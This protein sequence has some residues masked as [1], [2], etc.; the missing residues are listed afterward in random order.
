M[1][2]Y[3]TDADAKL[4][5]Q[6]RKFFEATAAVSFGDGSQ[7]HPCWIL[8]ISDGDARLNVGALQN[9]PDIFTL[10]VTNT[11]SVSRF[12]KIVWHRANEI[13]VRFVRP[14]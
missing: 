11:G 8:D 14:S 9:I 4:R 10:R 6:G 3:I 2:S 7:P 5:K 12:C 13:G 1:N